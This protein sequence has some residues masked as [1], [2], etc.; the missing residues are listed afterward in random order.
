MAKQATF[1]FV[2]YFFLL[3]AGCATAHTTDLR[4]LVAAKAAFELGCS[5]E[6]LKITQLEDK[7][8]GNMAGSV[9]NKSFGVEGCG[10]RASYDASCVRPMMMNE[11]CAANQTS[12]PVSVTQQEAPARST[13]R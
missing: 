13:A 4:P 5:A 2:L 7:S 6:N 8:Q 1:T 12:T 3:A 11:T 10:K 9:D